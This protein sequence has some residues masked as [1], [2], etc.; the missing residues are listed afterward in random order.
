MENNNN[1]INNNE[2]ENNI[3]ILDENNITEKGNLFLPIQVENY[4]NVISI[5]I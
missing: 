4:L 3:I 1:E 2:G 5:Y